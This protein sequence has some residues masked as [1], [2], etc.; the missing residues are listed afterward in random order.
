MAVAQAALELPLE[1]AIG[2]SGACVAAL[3]N[4]RELNPLLM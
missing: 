1:A 4:R 2:F 3:S